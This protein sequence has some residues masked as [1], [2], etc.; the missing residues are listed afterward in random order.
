MK[1]RRCSLEFLSVLDYCSGATWRFPPQVPVVSYRKHDDHFITNH[2]YANDGIFSVPVLISE[3]TSCA[4]TRKSVKRDMAEGAS[5]QTTRKH[6]EFQTS[7][8]PK[9]PAFSQNI[10]AG[11]LNTSACESRARP[12]DLHESSSPS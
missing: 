2:L 12:L 7:V 8:I 11:A 5:V 9:T 1:C 4:M 3:V 10:F 6:E